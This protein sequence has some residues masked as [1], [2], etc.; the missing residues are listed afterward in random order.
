MSSMKRH[1]TWRECQGGEARVKSV[2]ALGVLCALGR[3]FTATPVFRVFGEAESEHLGVP[4]GFVRVLRF[5]FTTLLLEVE[6]VALRVWSGLSAA[7]SAW[8]WS[9]IHGTRYASEIALVK[10]P[11][12]RGEST[13]DEG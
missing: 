1:P 4:S 11:V 6:H 3:R 8:S 10:A 13:R 12:A 9:K 7:D 5:C 2:L